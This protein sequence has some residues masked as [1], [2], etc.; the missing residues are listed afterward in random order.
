M[1]RISLLT[2]IF[3][4]I[5][6][7]FFATAYALQASQKIAGQPPNIVLIFT[8]DQGI[9]DVG[10]YGSEISTPNIDRLSKEG[11]K[12]SSWYVASSICTPSRYGLM[13]GRYPSRS[14]DRLLG[15][16]MFL[17]EGDASRGIHDGEV[18]IAQI[19]RKVGYRTALIGKWHLGHGNKGFLPVSHGFETFFGHTGGCVDYFT[20]RYGIKP[21]WYR[22]QQISDQS[23]YATNVITNEAVEFLNYQSSDKPFFLFLSYNA[24]HFGKGWNIRDQEAVNI[25]QPSEQDLLRV[26]Q[27]ED[28]IRRQFAAMVVTLDDGIGKVLQALDS[29]GL[30]D[31]TLVIFM[32][33]NGG[34]PDYGGSNTPYRGKK[35]TLFEGGIRVPCLMRWPGKIAAGT[36]TDAVA[37]AIDI[38]PTLCR[39]T[40][41]DSTPYE[42]DGQD[43]SDL[44]L[45]G[46]AG[47]RELFFELVNSSALRKSNWKYLQFEDG[48]KLLFDLKSDPSESKNLASER[49]EVYKEMKA[50]HDQI[51]AEFK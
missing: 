19:L 9:N 25:M 34:D 43:I 38:F 5:G 51:L 11:L 1:K 47:Q 33:D 45:A 28:P 30:T 50:R 48:R 37:G 32:T 23:G 49:P 3:F 42:L 29:K 8:D 15:A 2:T 40:G 44:I 18:T 27:I 16:L 46:Q 22:N 14:E 26:K 35:S 12:F 24:P 21:D 10:C 20:M 17:E 36:T 31:K 6:L 4:I 41:A 7:G 39:I 13:T